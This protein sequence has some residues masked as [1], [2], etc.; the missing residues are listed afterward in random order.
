MASNVGIP[1][2]LKWVEARSAC[3]LAQVFKELQAGIE[4]DVASINLTKRFGPDESF[5]TTLTANGTVLVITRRSIVGPRVVVMALNG[6][7]EIHD[8]ATGKNS[9]ADVALSDDGRCKLKIDERELE[10]WQ[11]RKLALES[12]FFDSY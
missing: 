5:G 3:S 12:L 9:V 10:Q 4:N 6:K 1:Q 2:D 11:V 7:I 8:E